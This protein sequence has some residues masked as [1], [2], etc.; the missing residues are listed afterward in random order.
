MTNA[1]KDHV[2]REVVNSLRD[3]ALKFHA[4]GSLRERLRE[5]LDPLLSA[6][7][8]LAAKGQGETTAWLDHDG[9]MTDALRSFMEGMSVSMDVSTG[10]HDAGN[11]YFGIINEV[12]DDDGDKNGVTLL[13]Y[14]AQPNFTAPA[15]AQPDRGAA[16]DERTLFEKWIASLDAPADAL[17]RWPDGRYVQDAIE[18][19]W[20]GWQARAAE[21]SP[22]SQP[23]APEAA[24][25]DYDATVTLLRNTVDYQAKRIA[26]YEAHRQQEAAPAGW[27]SRRIGN[28]AYGSWLHS[29]R[30]QAERHSAGNG[31]AAPKYETVPVYAAPVAAVAPSDAKDS[32]VPDHSEREAANATGKADAAKGELLAEEHRQR[33]IQAVGKAWPVWFGNTPIKVLNRLVWEVELAC[34]AAGQ[35]AANAKDA[36]QV[37]IGVCWSEQRCDFYRADTGLSMGSAFYDQW[38]D[39][40][41]EFPDRDTARAAMA[42]APSSEAGK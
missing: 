40:V 35:E 14:D 28:G 16:Q 13:V 6:S 38:R 36:A 2:L 20:G 29:S 42:A 39:R 17:E 26:E 41:D 1:V 5:C 19:Y 32:T 24:H 25:A 12:M 22:A 34:I 31:P 37:P 27:V 8:Q 21:P 15:S 7:A 23:V 4:H 10:E 30:E 9:R 11:R 33:I 18:G 3:T